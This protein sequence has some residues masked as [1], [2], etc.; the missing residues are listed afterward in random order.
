MPARVVGWLMLGEPSEGGEDGC[1]LPHVQF[2]A[3]LCV[4]FNDSDFDLHL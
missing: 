1:G 2:A 4:A 3:E